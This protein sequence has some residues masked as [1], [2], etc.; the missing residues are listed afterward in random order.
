MQF[1]GRSSQEDFDIARKRIEEGDTDA[2]ITCKKDNV[3]F[4]LKA[5]E[6]RHRPELFVEITDIVY[7]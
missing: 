1:L 4:I 5:D 2:S 3:L 6:E 7:S